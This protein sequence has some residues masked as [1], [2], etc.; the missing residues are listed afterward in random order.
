MRT[1]SETRFEQFC[2]RNGIK[3]ERVSET[4]AQTPDYTLTLNGQLV[5]VEVKEVLP[6]PE[7]T[8]SDRICKERGYGNVISITPGRTVRK[9]IA[10]WAATE[11]QKNGGESSGEQK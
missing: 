11:T 4:T 10:D 7:E 5:V 2:D 3:W 8:E 1:D 6:T 9:K